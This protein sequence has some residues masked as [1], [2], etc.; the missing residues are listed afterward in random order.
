M[1]TPRHDVLIILKNGE[2]AEGRS[3]VRDTTRI[4]QEGSPRL[5]T[6]VRPPDLGTLRGGPGIR[7][8]IEGDVPTDLL[9]SLD[10]GEALFVRAWEQQPGMKDKARPGEGLSWGAAGFKPP[11]P[12]Q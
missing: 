11:D 3:H 9:S 4:L 10:E 6:V 5:L 7:A 8:V 2:L 1:S 12:P